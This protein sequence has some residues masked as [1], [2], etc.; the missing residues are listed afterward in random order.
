MA[1]LKGMSQ[2]FGAKAGRK[3]QDFL[4]TGTLDPETAQRVRFKKAK[5]RIL[6]REKG[7]KKPRPKAPAERGPR[8]RTLPLKPGRKRPKRIPKRIR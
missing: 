5:S 8:F 7:P 1:G 4:E 6:A 2:V 3:L